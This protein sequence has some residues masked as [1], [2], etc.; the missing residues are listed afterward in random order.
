MIVKFCINDRGDDAVQVMAV[1]DDREDDDG[2]DEE[3][4]DDG[5]LKILTI[6]NFLRLMF[7]FVGF[8]T[9]TKKL[10]FQT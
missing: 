2:K 8:T 3:N 1:G 9:L 7:I 6:F 5:K 4:D 10:K